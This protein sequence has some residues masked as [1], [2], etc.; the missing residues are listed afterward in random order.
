[1][2]RLTFTGNPVPLGRPRAAIRG[3]FPS[4]YNDPKSVAEKKRIAQDAY[5]LLRAAGDK[6][7][8][9]PISADIKFYFE[10]PKISTKKKKVDMAVGII[11]HTKKPDIDNCIKLLLD[12]LN[13]LCYKDDSQ[14]IKI[15]AEKHYANNPGTIIELKPVKGDLL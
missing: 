15:T 9:G 2:I 14:I 13:G 7:I 6:P 10:I 8:E 11:K 5:V 1:M 4:I 12:A 3:R